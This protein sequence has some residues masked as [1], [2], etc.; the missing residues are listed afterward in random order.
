VVPGDWRAPRQTASQPDQEQYRFGTVSADVTHRERGR[1]ARGSPD[2]I[3]GN[4]DQPRPLDE[5]A[6]IVATTLPL[7]QVDMVGKRLADPAVEPKAFPDARR[8]DIRTRYSVALRAALDIGQDAV[9]PP[10]STTDWTSS[11]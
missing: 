1:R 7:E 3:A 11:D 10:A 5:R 4:G 2:A 9:W 8:R 6:E